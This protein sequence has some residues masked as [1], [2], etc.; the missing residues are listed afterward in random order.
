[1]RQSVLGFLLKMRNY[2]Y[3]IL[4]LL[5]ITMILLQNGTLLQIATVQ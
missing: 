3:K 2:Y 5:Q 4:Q 1:M